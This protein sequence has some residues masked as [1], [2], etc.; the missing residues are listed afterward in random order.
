MIVKMALYDLKFSG[1]AFRA[2]LD[3]VLHDLPYLPSKADPDV[4]IMP[5]FRP[6]GS[7]YY[8]MAL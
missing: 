7:E 3:G 1:A 4:W 5:S 2:K 8:E 6:D